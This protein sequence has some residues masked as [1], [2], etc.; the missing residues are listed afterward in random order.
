MSS[1]SLEERLERFQ[2]MAQCVTE[3]LD[4]A[5]ELALSGNTTQRALARQQLPMWRHH[6][7]QWR[8]ALERLEREIAEKG[9]N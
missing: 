6:V 4:L 3:N 5:S 1:E 8:V 2:E 7:E 9:G